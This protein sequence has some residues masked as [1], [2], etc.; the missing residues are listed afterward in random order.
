MVAILTP[1]ASHFL[2]AA[3]VNLRAATPVAHCIVVFAG[4]I[5]SGG[6]SAV[7]ASVH[8]SL[9]LVTSYC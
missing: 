7:T 6:P 5:W 9:C 4:D 1:K 3:A 2:I 8:D